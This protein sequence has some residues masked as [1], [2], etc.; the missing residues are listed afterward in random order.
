MQ[1]PEHKLWVYIR[2]GMGNRWLPQRHEDKHS[3]GIPD[4]SYCIN[5]S[6]WMELKY[7]PLPKNPDTVI[8]IKHWTVKQRNWIVS[9]GEK[10]GMCFVLL[11]VGS[12]YLL[13]GWDKCDLINKV[14]YGELRDAA[15]TVWDGRIDWNNLVT[16]IT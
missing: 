7:S 2:D 15:I 6:G 12:S 3:V 10:I 4:L 14:T 11:Q 1:D 16:L 9:R 8:K 5:R 13:I